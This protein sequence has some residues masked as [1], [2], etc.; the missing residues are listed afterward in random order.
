MRPGILHLRNHRLV[1]RCGGTLLTRSACAVQ[2]CLFP[3]TVDI[4]G[5]QVCSLLTTSPQIPSTHRIALQP[6]CTN[7]DAFL[8]D[9][10][11]VMGG[12]GGLSGTAWKLQCVKNML[13][14][15]GT[16]SCRP[17]MDGGF[18]GNLPSCKF[19]SHQHDRL[20]GCATERTLRDSRSCGTRCRALER[21]A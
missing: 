8:T 5:S 2:G 1:N 19:A 15:S 16:R 14:P 7:D 3:V 18:A 10:Q 12:A 20:V 9:P 4:L 13:A 21:R 6:R 17:W 11:V